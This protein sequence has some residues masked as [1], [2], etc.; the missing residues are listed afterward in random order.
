[1]TMMTLVTMTYPP[2]ESTVIIVT[3]AMEMGILLGKIA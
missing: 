1:M 2:G 3:T